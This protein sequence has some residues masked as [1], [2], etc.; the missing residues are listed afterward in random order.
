MELYLLNYT[1]VKLNVSIK[2][3]VLF[4]AHLMAQATN[5]SVESTNN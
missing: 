4:P 3:K 2:F 5:Y 1:V